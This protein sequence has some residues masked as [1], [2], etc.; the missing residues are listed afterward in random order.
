MEHNRPDVV[1]IDKTAKHW[2]II[3]FSVPWDTNILAK[4]AEKMENY[5]P[6][7]LEVRRVHGVSTSV[8]PIV[9]G[10]LGA[11]SKNLKGYLD[12]LNLPDVL[13][14]LQTSAILGTTNIIRKSLSI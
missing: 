14:G 9:V 11:V 2:T 1:V 4:E 6:L 5:N 7:A 10:A 8:V 13:G 12:H 3:D